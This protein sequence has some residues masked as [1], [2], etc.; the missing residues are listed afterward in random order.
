MLNVLP[1]AIAER[2]K[3]SQIYDSNQVSTNISSEILINSLSKLKS[4]SG[5]IVADTF[6][7]VTVLFGDIVSG[8][9]WWK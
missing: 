8:K 5:T 3:S 6:E 7:E 1:K 9:I 4:S 2:L